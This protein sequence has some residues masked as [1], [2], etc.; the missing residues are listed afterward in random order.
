MTITETP[1]RKPEILDE[2]SNVAARFAELRA[3]EHDLIRVALLDRVTRKD[4]AEWTGASPS[5]INAV[6]L[7]RRSNKLAKDVEDALEPIK[8]ALAGLDEPIQRRNL[9]VL[10]AF[11]QGAPLES[12]AALL[13]Q[14]PNWLMTRLTRARRDN[15]IEEMPYPIMKGAGFSDE[16]WAAKESEFKPLAKAILEAEADVEA[17][18][19]RLAIAAATSVPPRMQLSEVAR[20]LGAPRQQLYIAARR[21]RELTGGTAEAE[22]EPESLAES[23]TIAQLRSVVEELN[24][25]DARRKALAIEASELRISKVEI[26]GALGVTGTWMSR[27]LPKVEEAPAERDPTQVHIDAIVE[28]ASVARAAELLRGRLTHDALADGTDV[29][30]I[31]AAVGADAEAVAAWATGFN[32]AA[33]A[34]DAAVLDA[35]EDDDE[36][37]VLDESLDDE[38][39]EEDR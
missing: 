29:A 36:D 33:A 15:G 34:D 6:R 3:Q 32:S 35:D 21:G 27:V 37:A 10:E 16:E 19:D 11:Q 31:A 26:R 7:N 24:T 14:S 28:A 23:E 9:A 2:M 25:V 12:M 13:D 39:S 22:A 5:H 30:A 8:E 17:S 1:D 4:I 18:N 38:D 20:R